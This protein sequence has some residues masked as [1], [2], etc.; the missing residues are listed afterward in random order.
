ML[1][2]RIFIIWI[3]MRVNLVWYNFIFLLTEVAHVQMNNIWI[4][5]LTFFLRCILSTSYHWFSDLT[6]IVKIWLR[7]IF[8]LTSIKTKLIS[9]WLTKQIMAPSNMVQIYKMAT[10]NLYKINGSILIILGSIG[11]VIGCKTNINLIRLFANILFFESECRFLILI[12]SEHKFAYLFPL[13]QR[14]KRSSPLRLHKKIVPLS[15]TYYHI[16]LRHSANTVY[17]IQT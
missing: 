15:S 3:S 10:V 5:K 1:E 17:G 13:L 9:M 4:I 14:I 11:G 6:L 16:F 8:Q 7:S 12:Y 2:T